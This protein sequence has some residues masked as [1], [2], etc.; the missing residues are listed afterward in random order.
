MKFGVLPW[1]KYVYD[2]ETSDIYNSMVNAG[3]DVYGIAIN[4]TEDH[5][6]MIAS[7]LETMSFLGQRD[8]MPLYYE[9][10]LTYQDM[11][12]EDSIEMLEYIHEGLNY[13]FGY[14]YNP[15]SG[16][17]SLTSKVKNNNSSASR[18]YDKV[19]GAVEDALEKWAALDEK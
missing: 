1:P 19:Q 13:D 6:E 9:T 12:D 10:I 8:I 15:G 4:T 5:L 7:V 11:P 3:T 16:F 2:D 18:E 17:V 14:F